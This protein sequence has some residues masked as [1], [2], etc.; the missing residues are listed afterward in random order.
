MRVHR[1][2]CAPISSTAPALSFVAAACQRSEVKT[3]ARMALQHRLVAV[4]S[5]GLWERRSMTHTKV[6]PASSAARATWGRRRPT[7]TP[8]HVKHANLQ[9][10]FHE[11]S[12]AALCVP[13]SAAT[14]ASAAGEARRN[15]G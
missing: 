9:S 12:L 1:N 13:P 7:A 3:G 5:D 14:A 10:E 6:N 8:G 11:F 2:H 4:P 15:T